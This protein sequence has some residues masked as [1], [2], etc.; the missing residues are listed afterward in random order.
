MSTELT[1][2][3]GLTD[4]EFTNL[5][6]ST[7]LE[8]FSTS[9]EALTK[10]AVSP[11]K[12]FESSMFQL[13]FDKLQSKLYNLLPFFIGFELVRKSD[14]NSKAIGVFAFK[15]DNGQILFVPAFFINGKIKDLDIMYSRNNNQFYPLSEDFAELFLKDDAT[16]MGSVSQ[17]SRKEIQRDQNPVDFRN[18]AV[19]PRTGRTVL[20]SF[21]DYVEESDNIVKQATWDILEHNPGY[22]AALRGFY[23]DEKIAKALAPKK[24]SAEE[25][26]VK[27]VKF[28]QYAGEELSDSQKS[29]ITKQG[30]T[31][32]DK[33]AFT[34]KSKF[35]IVEI[36]QRFV[37]PVESGFY[38]YL[39]SLGTLRYGLVL[40]KPFRLH[41]DLCTDDVMVVDLESSM[42]GKTFIVDHPVYI[43][44]QI[45]VKDTSSIHKLLEEPAEALPSFSDT[46]VLIN[47]SL[48]T[49]I[50]FRVTYNSKDNNGVRRLK[51]EPDSWFECRIA[52]DLNKVKPNNKF[53]NQK[54][55]REIV[56]VF[57][58]KAGDKLEY[59]NHTTY[60]PKG[61]KM[62]RVRTPND[63]TG[64]EEASKRKAEGTP[65]LIGDLTS[66][67][68]SKQVVPMTVN[69][70]GSDYFVSIAAA[71]RHYDS[72]IKAKIAL[73]MDYGFDESD[74]TELLG[75]LVP[76]VTTKGTVKLA[77][78][79]DQ[80]LNLV[81]EAP[82]TNELGQQTYYG[83]PYFNQAPRSDGY[84][85]D[86]T[87]IGTI[88]AGEV[89]GLPPS[90]LRGQ[91]GGQGQPQ[92]GQGSGIQNEVNRAIQAAQ[93]GQ[94]EIF[95]T[96]SIATL[97]KYVDPAGKVT[98]YIPNFVSTLDK[99]GRML[100][101]LYW[102]TDKFKDMYGQDELP[103]LLELLKNVFKNLGDLIIFLKRK[104]PDLSI[105]S[106]GQDKGDI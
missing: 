64:C 27:L 40:I 7:P 28:A 102:E 49:S 75:S 62:L 91:G 34:E 53:F 35:G 48:K 10:S 25:P 85:G 82:S 20:A 97:A 69:T 1:K 47:E 50:P 39:T 92:G 23:S 36:P 26:K 95:D 16:G 14:D 74:A 46:Y 99:L 45:K 59:R 11:D 77:V 84:T 90:D 60:V 98:S 87:R 57:T 33:R 37:N 32:M 44:D 104:F 3:T 83:I 63:W 22:V 93:A 86:P 6:N 51:V 15:S 29:Q 94:K 12:E 81:D 24:A 42:P 88:D 78:L 43:K 31:L 101:M 65:G 61:Y 54:T 76:D 79:G 66:F 103:E 89:K 72:P 17:D 73:V 100:F 8:K 105:N 13:A 67:L 38:S 55:P 68:W 21:M 4:L 58:K 80:F 96:Q 71:K 18:L 56:L 70:N 52:P 2:I 30:Y 106:N 9:Y 19:P 5:L 41:E